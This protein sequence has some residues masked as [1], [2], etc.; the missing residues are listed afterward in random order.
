MKQPG[1]GEEKKNLN[2]D[3]RERL[4]V[5][6]IAENWHKTTRSCFAGSIESGKRKEKNCLCVNSSTQPEKR[7]CGRK[8]GRKVS[9]RT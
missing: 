1:H 3:N 9:T 8:G 4:A 5:G 2:K 7:Q 6:S